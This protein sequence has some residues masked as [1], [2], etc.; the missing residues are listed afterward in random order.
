MAVQ[1][2]A[3]PICGEHIGF[4]V[5]HDGDRRKDLVVD[6]DHDTGEVRGFVHRVCNTRP[7]QNGEAGRRWFDYCE[8]PPMRAAHG[9]R[10]L[11]SIK[12]GMGDNQLELS[13]PWV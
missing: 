2:D 13:L 8:H 10:P 6:H 3:C 1:N 4:E 12:S 9:G 11:I 5:R 7:P